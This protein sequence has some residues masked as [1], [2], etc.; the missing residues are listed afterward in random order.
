M[1]ISRTLLWDQLMPL[2]R[3][4]GSGSRSFLHGQTTADVAAQ[5]NGTIF[6]ACWLTATGR[7]RA[8]LEIRLDD[9]GA[10]VLVLGGDAENLLEGFAN[11]IFP[12]DQVKLEELRSVR[13]LQ[14]LTSS[15]V[16]QPCQMIWLDLDS[17][18][19]IPF[20]GIEKA[21]SEEFHYWR[22]NQGLPIGSGELD[23]QSNPLELGLANW[24]S[25]SKGCY[26]G[27]E[28][29]AKVSRGKK[30]KKELRYW[31]SSD[32]IDVGEK[33]SNF[34]LDRTDSQA[35][36]MISSS[37]EIDNGEKFVGLAMIRS[38]SLGEE[39]LFL[40][41]HSRIICLGIPIGFVNY[42]NVIEN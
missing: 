38:Q 16:Q 18:V 20:L 13:R 15:S 40:L 34:S 29:I 39:K 6:K 35:V 37:L 22:L 9:D 3:L 1:S 33:L 11:V 4:S 19:P 8:L 36:G 23:G 21:T 14:I 2:L 17:I 12:A 25:F 10:D 27:Q 31:E 32:Q 28:T 41:D 5:K 42:L 26:L 30:L 24:V 7:L